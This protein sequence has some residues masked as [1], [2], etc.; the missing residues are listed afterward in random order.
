M[1]CALQR[2]GSS[3]PEP[4]QA[5]GA[6]WVGLQW[7]AVPSWTPRPAWSTGAALVQAQFT[8][9]GCTSFSACRQER[10]GGRTMQD[11]VPQMLWLPTGRVGTKGRLGAGP[12]K[13][14]VST[15]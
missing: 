6:G 15:D 11:C 9:Q 13:S 1:R 14:M 8:I 10:A 4:G 12:G 3:E 7:G 2:C 5:P